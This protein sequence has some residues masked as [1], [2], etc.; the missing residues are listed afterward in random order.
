M[1]DGGSALP[2]VTSGRCRRN[3]KEGEHELRGQRLMLSCLTVP[4]YESLCFINLNN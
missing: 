3:G 2:R 1:C 4:W